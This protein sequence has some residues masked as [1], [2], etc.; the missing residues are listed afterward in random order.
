MPSA[1]AAE[2]E[3]ARKQ[4]AL[5]G[6]LF[7]LLAII[8]IVLSSILAVRVLELDVPKF[9]NTGCSDSNMYVTYKNVNL[10]PQSTQAY[11]IELAKT[12]SQ[13]ELGL[14]DRPCYPSDGALLFMFPTDDKFGIWMKNMKF[15]IDT[16]WLDSNKKIV[17]I[18]HN[19]APESYPR[20]FYP[21]ADARYVLE[22]NAGQASSVL[23]ADVGT[24]LHW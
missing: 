3:L 23:K 21:Q 18:E 7:R 8:L 24:Q 14:T 5:V 12:P 13:L 4:Q 17:H 19:M 9:G 1:A 16:I 15:N 10:T 6:R 20:V 22:I 11:R 2:T